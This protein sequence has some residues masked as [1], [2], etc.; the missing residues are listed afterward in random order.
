MF[1]YSFKSSGLLGQAIK[2]SC[3]HVAEE[4]T[5]FMLTRKQ[6]ENQEEPVV[7]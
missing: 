3:V 4:V 7:L 1:I 2:L 5:H 6:K